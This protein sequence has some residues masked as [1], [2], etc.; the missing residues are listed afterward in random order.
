MPRPGC[1][2]DE[3][4]WSCS[5]RPFRGDGTKTYTCVCGRKWWCY[6]DYYMLWAEI[7]DN[8]T[9]ANV[10]AGCPEPVQVGGSL[11]VNLDVMDRERV[12]LWGPEGKHFTDGILGKASQNMFALSELQREAFE[13]H[14]KKCGQCHDR[15]QKTLKLK[16]S[17]AVP[18]GER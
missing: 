10:Q 14:L 7:K 12:E 4:E 6:N 11:A 8:S 18:P 17:E 9:W 15:W 3:I 16:K 13:D 2:C 5:K 1:V